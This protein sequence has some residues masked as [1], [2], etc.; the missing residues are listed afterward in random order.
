MSSTIPVTR[1][2]RRGR[3]PS[4]T[5]TW[6]TSPGATRSTP[7]RMRDSS[8]PP[9]GSV[10]TRPLI[11]TTRVNSGSAAMPV[12]AR[13][14][15]RC[16]ALRRAATLRC[17]SSADDAGDPRGVV[18]RARRQRHHERNG[19]VLPH[20][21]LELPLDDHVNRVDEAEADEQHGAAE[22][23]ADDGRERSERLALHVAQH[24]AGA[25]RQP[26][27]DRRQLDQAP[28]IRRRRLGPHGLGRRDAYGTPDRAERPRGRGD[29][30]ERQGAERD[31]P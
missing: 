20:A 8:S 9:G 24:H 11:S 4:S 5:S 23:D 21:V 17:S 15:E 28:A 6:S 27:L 13:V 18:H 12:I 29:Q 25:V 30:A 26:P 1:T 31:G 3:Q 14:R 2:S 22:R 7:A 10:R 19:R 16:P